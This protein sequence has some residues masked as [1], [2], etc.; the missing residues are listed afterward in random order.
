MSYP[1]L[2]GQP[3]NIHISNI[4]PADNVIFMNIYV[5]THTYNAYNL[6]V[7]KLEFAALNLNYFHCTTWGCS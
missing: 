5:S 4:I 1:M 6:D 7:L 2:D 3:E